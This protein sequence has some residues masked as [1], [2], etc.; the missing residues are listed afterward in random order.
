[1]FV[2]RGVVGCI[3][4]NGVGLVVGLVGAK[5]GALVGADVVG[6]LVGL[7]VVGLRVGCGVVGLRVGCGVVVGIFPRVITVQGTEL[8]RLWFLS[9]LSAAHKAL[10][11]LDCSRIF[12]S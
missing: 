11:L 5:D 10:P 2:G 3:D 8:R 1:M 7:G 4:G 12:E 9:A 6:I